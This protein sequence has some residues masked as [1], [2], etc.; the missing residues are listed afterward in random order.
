[1]TQFLDDLDS[2]GARADDGDLLAA[3]LRGILFPFPARSVVNCALELVQAGDFGD[4]EF[5]SGTRAE[6]EVLCRNFGVGVSLGVGA[7]D[8]P[9]VIV[10]VEF[11]GFDGR[12]EL[13]V[14]AEIEFFIQ[15]AEV[16]EDF[17]PAGKSLGVVEVLVQVWRGE[18]HGGKNIL[19]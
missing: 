15:V 16:P 8:E 12:I 2:A 13:D 9:F 17:V 5:P 1:M 19:M 14:F 10:G 4:V 6:D 3:K 18:L 7:V 11:G